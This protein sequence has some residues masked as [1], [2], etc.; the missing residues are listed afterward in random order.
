MAN[1]VSAKRNIEMAELIAK[2][3]VNLKEFHFLW[4]LQQS[5]IEADCQQHVLYMVV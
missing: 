3:M 1:E 5:S 2:F 4:D